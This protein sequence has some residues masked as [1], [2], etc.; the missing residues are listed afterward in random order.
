MY[1]RRKWQPTPVSLPRESQGRGS[2]VGCHL[3]G[4]TES[5]TTEA[6][7]QQQQQTSVWT[8]VLA[9]LECKCWTTCYKYMQFYKQLLHCL[10]KWLHHSAL[11]SAMNSSSCCSTFSVRYGV[12]S[13]PEFGHSYF[14]RARGAVPCRLW[15]TG[16]SNRCVPLLN[17]ISLMT[18]N[19][20]HFSYA[21]LLSVLLSWVRCLFRCFARF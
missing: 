13:I 2:P 15:E 20:E 10:P 4:L 5:N 17:C 14:G 8:Y 16:H 11:P 21:Y 7:Q 18:Y 12:V 1:W 3:W 6:T 19:V 9:H